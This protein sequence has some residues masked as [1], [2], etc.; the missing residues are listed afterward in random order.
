MSFR[1]PFGH[2]VSSST[3][4]EMTF[5]HHFVPTLVN[6][7]LGSVNIKCIYIFEHFIFVFILFFICFL[8]TNS[9]VGSVHI[10]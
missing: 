10:K 5:E 4:Y 1:S 2:F 6:S 7:Y 8:L 9:Y 3:G